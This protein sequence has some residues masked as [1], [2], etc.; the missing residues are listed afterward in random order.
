MTSLPYLTS[1]LQ[2]MPP[3]CTSTQRSNSCKV[4]KLTEWTGNVGI[5]PSLSSMIKIPIIVTGI[6]SAAVWIAKCVC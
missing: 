5:G 3:H 2:T 6:S 1:T 4:Q